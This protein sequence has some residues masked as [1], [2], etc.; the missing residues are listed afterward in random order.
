MTE[1]ELTVWLADMFHDWIDG[2]DPV[3]QY[4]RSANNSIDVTFESGVQFNVKITQFF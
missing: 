3:E 2:D 1:Q 4:N